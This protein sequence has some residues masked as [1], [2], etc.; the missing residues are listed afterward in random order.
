MVNPDAAARP[1]RKIVIHPIVLGQQLGDLVRV[2]DRDDP[3]IS[4]RET[5]DPCSR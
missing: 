5:A 1:E 4:D 2:D 3:G